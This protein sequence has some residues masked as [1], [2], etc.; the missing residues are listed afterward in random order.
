[1]MNL[2]RLKRVD[3]VGESQSHETC[4]RVREGSV[5]VFYGAKSVVERYYDLSKTF[6][7]LSLDICYGS[8][9]ENKGVKQ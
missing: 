6:Q 5:W 9:L 7:D 2:L 8:F 3:F 4:M 1:M